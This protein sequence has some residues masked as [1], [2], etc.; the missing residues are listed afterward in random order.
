MVEMHGGSVRNETEPSIVATFQVSTEFSFCQIDVFP[1]I[2][3]RVFFLLV[4][5]ISTPHSKQ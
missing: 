5:Q 3:T 2:C 1:W 4:G